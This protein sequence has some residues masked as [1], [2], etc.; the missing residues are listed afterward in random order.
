[1]ISYIAMAL[2]GLVAISMVGLIGVLLLLYRII[3]VLV[4]VTQEL[5]W[6][7]EAYTGREYKQEEKIGPPPDGHSAVTLE[8]PWSDDREGTD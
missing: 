5:R 3:T 6:T 1:M 4:T 7:A 2:W 8:S